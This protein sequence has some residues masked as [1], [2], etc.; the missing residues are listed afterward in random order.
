MTQNDAVEIFLADPDATTAAAERLASVLRAGDCL[1]LSGQIGAGKTHFA[2]ALIQEWLRLRG[3]WDD[4]PSPTFT[5]VQTYTD[6][7][8]EIWHADLYRLTSSADVFELGL[9]AAFDSAIVIVEWPD[10]LGSNV[11][12]SATRMEFSLHKNGRLLKAYGPARLLET[13]KAV[14]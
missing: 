1:L 8:N 9:D 4:V 3:L 14:R 2:R 12:E 10:R 13:M 11:P 5:L 7:T 6:G